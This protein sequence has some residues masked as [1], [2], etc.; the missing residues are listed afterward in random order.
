MAYM[1]AE[2]GQIAFPCQNTNR[3]LKDPNL[4]NMIGAA[5]IHLNVNCC[6]FQSFDKGGK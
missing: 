3:N 4:G 2:F 6:S 1:T 5:D